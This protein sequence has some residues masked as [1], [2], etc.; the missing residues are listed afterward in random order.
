MINVQVLKRGIF[1]H[2]QG[3]DIMKNE[4]QQYF[5]LKYFNDF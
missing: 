3:N 2:F 4:K 1:R 5:N